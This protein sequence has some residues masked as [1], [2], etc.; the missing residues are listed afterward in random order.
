MFWAFLFVGI[1]LVLFAVVAFAP[2]VGIRYVP[3]DKVGIVESLWG[4]HIEQGR[5]I[6]LQGETGFQPDVLRGGIFFNLFRWKYRIHKV[7]LVAIPQGKIGYIYA[8]DG[9]ALAPS[10]TI[11]RIARCNNFQDARAFL[12]G[13]EDG[14]N[15]LGQRGRQRA[16]LREGVYAI[17]VALFTVIAEDQFY[18]LAPIGPKSPC[19]APGNSNWNRSTDSTRS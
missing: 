15:L 7:P 10:Q 6:A 12:G 17:N 11:G 8:R 2:W 4:R 3:N 13:A 5:I 19:S 16:V 18:A 14:K 9:E 1:C